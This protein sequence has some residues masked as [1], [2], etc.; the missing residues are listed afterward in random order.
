[1]KR[2]VAF[3]LLLCVVAGFVLSNTTVAKTASWSDPEPSGIVAI[4][5]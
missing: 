5:K 2:R 1:M 4:Y 3:G